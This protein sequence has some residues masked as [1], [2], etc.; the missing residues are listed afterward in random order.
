MAAPWRL[1]EKGVIAAQVHLCS[2][3]PSN[4]KIPPMVS[5]VA[6]LALPAQ[7][8][9]ANALRRRDNRSTARW[10]F[11]PHNFS[12]DK[13]KYLKEF[14]CVISWHCAEHGNQIVQRPMTGP[15]HRLI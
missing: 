9:Y 8:H 7:P 4:T 6:P 13:R 1:S 11:S 2:S 5:A 10:S 15:R 14:L 12:H 3:V